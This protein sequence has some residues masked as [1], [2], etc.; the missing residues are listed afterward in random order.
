MTEVVNCV[1]FDVDG[2]LANLEHRLHHVRG[3][4]KDYAAFFD[5]MPDDAP[6]A[7]VIWLSRALCEA[8]TELE[9]DIFICSGRPESHREQTLGWLERHAPELRFQHLSLFMRADGDYRPD[10]VV[11]DEM[12]RSIEARGYRIALVV[13]DR[14]SVVDMWRGHGITCLQVAQWDE[15]PKADVPGHLHVMVGPS[16]AGKTTLVE[17][18][19]ADGTFHASWVISSDALRE[20]FCGTHR[21]MSKDGLMWP[22]LHEVVRSR[23]RSGLPVVVDATNLK[24]R[25]RRAIADLAPANGG[26]T[27]HVVDRPLDEKFR[28]GGWRNDV[29]V[30]DRPLIEYHDQVFRSNLG[31]ILSGDGDPRVTVVDHRK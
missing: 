18:L 6:K 4:R 24:D 1:V 30:K 8:Q 12:R 7:D 22:H 5:A 3:P 26:I 28:D 31:A 2:T 19:V 9:F 27:Y 11:K 13:D 17:A 14:Q 23:I 15:Q 29:E 21:D 20:E 10:T 16:G 25:D